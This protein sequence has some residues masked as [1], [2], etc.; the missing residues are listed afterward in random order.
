MFLKKVILF[1]LIFIFLA[2][3]L[4]VSFADDKHKIINEET[5][6]KIDE[7]KHEINYISNIIIAFAVVTSVLI[8]IIHFIRLSFHAN[9]PMFRA[10]VIKDIM[11]TGVCTGLIGAI[12]I[13]VKIYI[14]I[15]S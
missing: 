5:Y 6:E 11:I 15:F 9:Q 14:N 1:F 2:S 4:M 12:S 13:I 10:L 7:F 3:S 8:F